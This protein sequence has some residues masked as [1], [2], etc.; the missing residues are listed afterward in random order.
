MDLENFLEGNPDLFRQFIVCKHWG[1]FYNF[2][3]EKY[4]EEYGDSPSKDD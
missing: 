1:E 2:L 4:A 3:Q